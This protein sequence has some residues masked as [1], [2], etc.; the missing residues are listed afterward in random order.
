M[1]TILFI[2]CMQRVPPLQ[3]VIYHVT[4]SGF[5][6]L[7][8]LL[9]IGVGRELPRY[10]TQYIFLQFMSRFITDV[11]REYLHYEGL[12]VTLQLVIPSGDVSP[13][14]ASSLVDNNVTSCMNTDSCPNN[15]EV[16]LQNTSAFQMFRIFFYFV[17]L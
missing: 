6:Y 11:W 12:D 2:T 17:L 7:M 3:V 9:I 5:L 15:G 10:E 4:P 16:S 1:F 14:E 8:I 13:T